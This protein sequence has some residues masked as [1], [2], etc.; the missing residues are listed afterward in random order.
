M[1][2]Y[3]NIS[4]ANISLRCTVFPICN[5]IFMLV[6]YVKIM[7]EFVR[8]SSYFN[9]SQ[10][11]ISLHCTVFPICNSMTHLLYVSPANVKITRHSNINSNIILTQPTKGRVIIY[12]ISL[13]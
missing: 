13:H 11:N 12:I 7:L 1:S 3:F 2:S 4:Q 8:M 5:V 10:A 9:I 6:G